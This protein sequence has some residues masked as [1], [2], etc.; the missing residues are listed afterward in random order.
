[1]AINLYPFKETILRE[2]AT[3]EEAVENI[4]I[5][6]PTMLRA[7][8]KNWQDVAVIVDP[9]DYAKV[10]GELKAA[11]RC[12]GRPSWPSPTRCFP[13]P[14]AMT[15]LIAALSEK[16]V[17]LRHLPRKAD[18]DLREG[19]GDALRREPAPEAVFYKEIGNFPGTLVAAKQLHG[20]E[21]SYNNINDANGA[22]D[23]VK[24][25]SSPA[26][27]AVKHANPCGTGLG[28]TVFEAYKKA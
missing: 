14:Q 27:V 15:R 22:L 11:G 23:L 4:D 20:K 24:E 10:V 5:G 21:L 1:M 6:G 17:R 25:F 19:A 16:D 18:P 3:F 12:P 9:A 26:V 2:G 7:A 8:A 13:P 28:E